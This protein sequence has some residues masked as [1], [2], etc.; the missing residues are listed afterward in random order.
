MFHNRSASLGELHGGH[1]VR[2]ASEGEEANLERSKSSRHLTKKK[3]FRFGSRDSVG[4][5][6]LVRKPSMKSV[7]NMVHKLM[8]RMSA[9]Q[10]P[11]NSAYSTS[12]IGKIDES[13]SYKK[14][15][16]DVDEEAASKI[17]RSKSMEVLSMSGLKNHGN[18]CFMNSIIQCLAHTDLLAE[19]FV[20]D[21]YKE[22]LKLRKG[23]T[24]KFGTRGEVTEKL[25][26]LLK[27]L[28]SSQYNSQISSDFKSIV[29]KYGVQYRGYAQHDAQ[30]FLLWLLDKVHEDLNRA[31]KR[32]YKA[33]KES[34]G[35]SDDTIALEALANHT[36]CNDS[37]VLDLFQAQYRSSL[38]C[39]RCHQQ[40][41]TFDPFLCLSL[42][43]PQRESR[44]IIVTTVFVNSSRV[45]LRIGVSVPINGT[46]ADLRNVVSDMTGI[47]EQSLILTELYHDGFHRT[48]H[49]KQSLSI[50]HEGDNIYAFE[51]PSGL[52]PEMETEDGEAPVMSDNK[53]PISDTILILLANCQGPAKTT[54]SKRFGLPFIVR[55][56]RELSYEN[57]QAA[58]LKA[59]SRILMDNMSSQIK[60]QGLVFRLRVINGLPGKGALSPEVDHPLYQAT[61]DRALLS[62]GSGSGPK[63]IKVMAE[64][65]QE[66]RVSFVKSSVLQERPEEHRSV[67][68]VESLHNSSHN[69]D[70]EDCFR[71]YTKDEKLGTEDAWLCPR[72]KKLQQGTVK[73]LS[74]WSLPEVLVVH[75]KR[76]RQTSAGRTKL[77]T[78][79][80]FPLTGLDVTEH[81]EPRTKRSSPESHS[82]GWG[83]WGR[84]RAS[85][86]SGSDENLYDLYAVCNHTGGM[87]GGHYTAYCK[88]PVDFTWY[89]FDDM[90]VE[91]ISKHQIVTKAAYL[92]FYTRRNVGS[93]SASESSSGS[94]HWV[95]RMPQFSYESVF[96]SRDEL[97]SKEDSTTGHSANESCSSLPQ[98]QEKN[99][100]NKWNSKESML[101]ESCV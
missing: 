100:S 74:L 72:C 6:K 38:K 77:H 29:G 3:S 55:V 79:V 11:S 89:L 92:L 22:D 69:V 13:A 43:I 94:E 39:P 80:D 19:Y 5:R 51:A 57:L 25:A 46:I 101:T 31:T 96:S 81:V 75:L 56:L 64:W 60:K 87:T 28:W 36:R 12:S 71:L 24:K 35:R 53:G 99:T 16:F 18:T 14:K 95:W 41:T 20:M 54:S 27:S 52:F 65:D 15:N 83:T 8:I 93:S 68:E 86:V 37:F 91:K 66:T 26:L 76:F 61:V 1:G 63:H 17:R 62:C 7:S 98:A 2:E 84:K 88:N 33:N 82:L 59:M 97:S 78:L 85:S 45:P 34:S 73:R 67:R 21:Q 50:V 90:R 42:P 47:S 23:Q 9:V 10:F 48:F 32:K 4:G 30:E 49:D 40:S 58:I 70:L 44:P